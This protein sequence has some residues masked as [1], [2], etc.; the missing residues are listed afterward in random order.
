M[1]LHIENLRMKSLNDHRFPD[2]HQVLGRGG[3][4]SYL[5]IP[6][7]AQTHQK[8]RQLGKDCLQHHLESLPGQFLPPHFKCVG[9]GV[10]L[11]KIRSQTLWDQSSVL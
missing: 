6:K 9:V 7:V 5:R 2:R 11:A 4:I 8:A 10:P 3:T 1:S